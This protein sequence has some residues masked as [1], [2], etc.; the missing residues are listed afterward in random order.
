MVPRGS[1]LRK[2]CGSAAAVKRHLAAGTII[3]ASRCIG[4]RRKDSTGGMQ[5]RTPSP[6]S[7][8]HEFAALATGRGNG[9]WHLFLERCHCPVF[10][11]ARLLSRPRRRCLRRAP[12]VVR[13]AVELAR[14]HLAAASAAHTSSVRAFLSRCKR[15]GAL[16]PCLMTLFVTSISSSQ[17]LRQNNWKQGMVW[18]IR[19]RRVKSR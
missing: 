11:Y 5:T 15:P 17:D 19:M 9:D 2:I 10:G 3:V 8:F 13:T 14:V 1:D 4:P 18:A 16:G 6:I 7:T 12:G